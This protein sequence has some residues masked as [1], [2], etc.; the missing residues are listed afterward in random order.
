MN[1]L[2]Y[3]L[4]KYYILI[5]ITNHTNGIVRKIKQWIKIQ[6][7]YLGII[8]IGRFVFTKFLP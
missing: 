2:K 7:I 4:E 3:I 8:I 5:I 1:S 6:M